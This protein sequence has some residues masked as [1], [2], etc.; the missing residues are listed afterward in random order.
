MDIFSR[1]DEPKRFENE[2]DVNRD[3]L[4]GVSDYDHCL[5]RTSRTLDTT[6]LLNAVIKSFINKENVQCYTNS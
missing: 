3:L 1:K 5:V 2:I 6:K 4:P